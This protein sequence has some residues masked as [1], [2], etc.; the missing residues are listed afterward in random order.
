MVENWYFEN[1]KNIKRIIEQ[2][3]KQSEKQSHENLHRSRMFKQ[4]WESVVG[5]LEHIYHYIKCRKTSTWTK[6][7]E[8]AEKADDYYCDIG[9]QMYLSKACL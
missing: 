1:N 9:H 4:L 2:V 7:E 5:S 3:Q 6:K 8:K